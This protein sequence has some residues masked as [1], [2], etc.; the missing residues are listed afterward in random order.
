MIKHLLRIFLVACCTCAF[1]ETPTDTSLRELLKLTQQDHVMSTYRAVLDSYA[2]A[3][4]NVETQTRKLTDAQ[5]ETLRKSQSKVTAITSQMVSWEAI[6]PSLLELYRS[7]LSQEQ[8]DQVL[9]M[10]KSSA[11]KVYSESV[12]PIQTEVSNGVVQIAIRMYPK[13]DEEINRLVTDILFGEKSK[14]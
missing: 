4:I 8:V 12:M 5:R 14:T 3:R 6:E 13:I 2:I 9:L 10:L 7:K 11:W 1:A